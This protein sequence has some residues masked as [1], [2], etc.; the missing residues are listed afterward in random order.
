[1]QP[2]RRGS[3]YYKNTGLG[4]MTTTIKGPYIDKK[5]LLLV[6]TP[7]E[8]MVVKMRMQRTTATHEHHLWS[9]HTYSPFEKHHRNVSV[10]LLPFQGCA[11]WQHHQH[12]QV[13]APE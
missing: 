2:A 7:S 13:Q 1:M 4:F 9:I 11:D 8:D 6:T 5:H 3:L 12:G 10:H